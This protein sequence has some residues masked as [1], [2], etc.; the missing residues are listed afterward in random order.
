MHL[1]LFQHAPLFPEQPLQPAVARAAA[2][3]FPPGVGRQPLP[4]SSLGLSPAGR[5]G[6]DT[7]SGAAGSLGL[8]RRS[9]AIFSGERCSARRVLSSELPEARVE[10]AISPDRRPVSARQD[11]FAEHLRNQVRPSVS[12]V[13][14]LPCAAV[15]QGLQQ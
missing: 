12:H 10:G 2:G 6:D 8:R 4:L 13:S 1:D 14:R 3:S 9:V 11:G 15:L 7:R 5:V